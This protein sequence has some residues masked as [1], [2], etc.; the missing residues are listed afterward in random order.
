MIL[1]NGNID[2]F[3]HMGWTFT[4]N[5][6]GLCTQSKISV[7]FNLNRY[8]WD[9]ASNKVRFA[10]EIIAMVFVVGFCLREF[11]SMYEQTILAYFAKFGSWVDISSL[12][13]CITV[14]ILTIW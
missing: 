14:G 13:L 8:S 9:V 2:T 4:F 6:A 12:M 7:P 10:F 5:F 11:H 3:L 1:Y